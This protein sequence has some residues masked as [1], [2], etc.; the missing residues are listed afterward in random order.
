MP[1]R[2]SRASAPTPAACSAS[3]LRIRSRKSSVDHSSVAEPTT[4]SLDGS[5]FCSVSWARPGISNRRGRSP[6]APKMTMRSITCRSSGRQ[7]RA[8]L[9][10]DYIGGVPLGPLGVTLPGPALVLAVRSLG[11]PEGG[12]QIGRGGEG[13]R[14][15]IEAAGKPGGDLLQQPAVPVRIAERGEG[16]VRLPARGRTVDAP[17][18]V[19]PVPAGEVEDLA[20]IHPAAQ[21][22]GAR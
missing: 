19:Q 7:L 21:Q 2:R 13:R 9:L 12:G 6:D 18:R 20:D 4:L 10:G 11:A 14:P 1:A 22:L 16:G 3:A 5:A 15:R 8:G 17:L